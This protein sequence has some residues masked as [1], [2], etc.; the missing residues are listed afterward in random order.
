MTL[1]LAWL[2]T[3]GVLLGGGITSEEARRR[4]AEENPVA[5]L[6]PVTAV[7]DV[8]VDMTGL[9]AED[10]ARRVEVIADLSPS[11]IFERS[12]VEETVTRILSDPRY[13]DHRTTWL[14]DLLAPLNRLLARIMAYV[15][16]GLYRLLIR[17]VEFLA[18]SPW[19]WPVMVLGTAAAGV[20]VW[21]LSRRRARDIERQVAIE[22]ILG[23]GLD[24]AE[25]ESLATHAAIGGDFAE[26]IRLR[27]VAG[28]LRLDTDGRIRFS[29]G[30]PNGVFSQHLGSPTFD[31]LAHQFDAAVYGRVPTGETDHS[32]CLR[33]W[34]EL[35]GVRA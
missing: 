22:R 30:T 26:A 32:E 35:L 4:A 19:R 28:L 29:P 8:P 20:G 9:L 12:E 16:D 10:G 34:G 13:P 25:L 31:R 6:S 24:P 33:L 1:V 18:E 14:Q 21:L 3:V 23:L 2:L 11:P 7:D 15:M 5:R 17:V 27:F